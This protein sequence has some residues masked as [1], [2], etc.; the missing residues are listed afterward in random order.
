MNR[1]SQLTS[2]KATYLDFPFRID[3]SGRTS[4]TN[5]EDHVGNLIEQILFTSPGER[6]NRP[7]FGCG[8]QR[9]V[10]QPNSDLMASTARMTAEAAIQQ[11]LSHLIDLVS[12]KVETADSTLSVEVTYTLKQMKENRTITLQR[13]R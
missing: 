13:N 1:S 3:T 11:H 4:T 6:V 2:A 7:A 12:L 9:A 10:F 8:L 5:R